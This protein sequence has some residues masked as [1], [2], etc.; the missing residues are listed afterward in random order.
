MS[1]ISTGLARVPNLLMS[2]LSL[3]NLN[4]TNLALFDTYNQISTGKQV[5]R[6][7]DDPVRAAAI[8]ALNDRLSRSDQAQ[9]NLSNASS[10]LGVLDSTLTEATTLAQ[11]ARSIAQAQLSIT[12]SPDERRGQAQI[13]DQMIRS[14]LNISQ[15]QGP[16]GY[17]LGGSITSREPITDFLGG[18]KYQGDGPG[19]VTDTA[20]AGNVPITLAANNAL[21]AMSAR[22]RGSVDLNPS[23]SS[24]TRLGEIPGARGLGI[25]LGV[26]E[27]SVN[28][29]SRVQVDLTGSDGIS[30]ITTRLQNA[31]RQYETDNGVTALGPLGVS[32]SSGSVT[33]DMAAGATLQFF[34]V[35]T[36]ST[37]ADLGL[38]TS[39]G[40]TF[41]TAQSAGVD[42]NPRLSWDTPIGALAGANG[43]LGAIRVKALGRS[44]DIDLS[45]A[46]TLEDLK[47]LIEGANLGLRVRINDAGSG[48]DVLSDVAAGAAG[49]MS[50]EEVPGNNFTATHLGI[51]TLSDTTALSDFN[52]G[53]GVTINDGML[54]PQT[55]LPDPSLDSDFTITLG[56]AARTTLTIDLRPVDLTSVQ[57][58]IA[59]I[60][61]Q[62]APQLAA[63]GLA[64]TDF[65]AGLGSGSNGITFWQSSA[66][67]G[68]ISVAPVNGSAAAENLGL[69]NASYDA[70]SASLTGEDR[71]KVRVDN[72]FTRLIDLRDALQ[73]N[74]TRGISLAGEGIDQHVTGLAEARGLVGGY[75]QRVEAAATR[76]EDRVTV[77]TSVRSELQDVD[78][79][80][81]ATRLNLLQ[82][83]LTAGMRV[84]A[85]LQQYTLL[86]FLG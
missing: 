2:Q 15:R 29:G 71:A 50:I 58:L 61:S 82:T 6:V 46:T 56:N 53:R 26:V 72:L 13:V 12:S 19:L 4:R 31:L 83:Q 44:V 14:L 64:P 24:T 67:T 48:I 85:Q 23:L 62:A 76:E 59:R 40:L 34:D 16:S 57:T 80:A 49:A 69:L 5:S 38:A 7:S 18:Y 20:A 54:N 41:S 25:S 81:A 17:L 51:R 42:L 43:P 8:S 66:F 36:N 22:V 21:G 75:A 9:R 73:T 37:A 60:N 55:G 74:D 35:A 27:F 11:E 52:F 78:F 77:D 28:G 84:T 70:T 32:T 10:N 1:S 65:S 33:F 30:D 39:A 79:T 47:N 86:D 3:A 68:A 63:A 45:Q